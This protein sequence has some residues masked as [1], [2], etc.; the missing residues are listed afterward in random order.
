MLKGRRLPCRSI[1]AEW[2]RGLPAVVGMIIVIHVASL[3]PPTQI[4]G[5]IRAVAVML[6]GVRLVAPIYFWAT[7]RFAIEQRGVVATTGMLSVRR[8]AVAWRDIRV[9]EAD[10]PWAH[11]LLG[12]TV[13]RLLPAGDAETQI[14]L[15]GVGR[16]T[17]ERL[18]DEVEQ[19]RRLAGAVL[20][21]AHE[22]LQQVSEPSTE[23]HRSVVSLGGVKQYRPNTGDLLLSCIVQG[24]IFFIALS[25]AFAGNDL[26]SRFGVGDAAF[27]WAHDNMVA[28]GL[29]VGTF[30]AAGAFAVTFVRYGRLVIRQRDDSLELQYGL[31]DRTTR[32]VTGDALVGVIVRRNL[33][34]MI[35]DRV[36]VSLITSDGI[37]GLGQN[38]VLPTIPRQAVRE[39][40]TI[41]DPDLVQSS[42]LG[43][44]GT[45][46]ALRATGVLTLCATSTVAVWWGVMALSLTPWLSVL[47]AL[48]LLLAGFVFARL[49]GTRFEATASVVVAHWHLTEDH[50]ERV[51]SDAIHLL[52][53]RRL[54]RLPLR[55]VKL[56]YFAGA[57]RHRS[58][59]MMNDSAV[60]DIVMAMKIVTGQSAL[61]ART[62]AP[63]LRGEA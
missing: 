12:L 42:I 33:L 21:D 25:V 52:R 4:T 26:L 56:T 51:R 49:L 57:P 28:A 37:G 58:G 59:L 30:V 9:I 50:E 46:G 20:A 27:T 55:L 19:A 48:V 11:R 36:R 2:L 8:D 63:L 14:R 53:E 18:R 41:L 1:L 38:L 15:D 43:S 44:S 60:D 17:V 10:E 3:Q 5:W 24:K 45:A 62:R 31:L 22:E 35:C 6:I 61:S 16:H 54:R 39:A 40:L 7:T 32:V 29:I 47:A 13:V 34:E 23:D